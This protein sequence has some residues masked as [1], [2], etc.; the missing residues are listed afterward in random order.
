MIWS[1]HFQIT[2]KTKRNLEFSDDSD[3]EDDD[4]NTKQLN[5]EQPKILKIKLL[6]Q[7][8]YYNLCYGWQAKDVLA[9]AIYEKWIMKPTWIMCDL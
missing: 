4:T 9:K 2:G 7:I 8:M 5:S 3:D 6:F 1:C